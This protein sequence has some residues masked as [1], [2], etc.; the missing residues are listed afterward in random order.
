VVVRFQED[1]SVRLLPIPRDLWDPL[2]GRRVNEALMQGA[3][4]L[5]E[6]VRSA[7]GI[8]I[9]HYVEIDVPG[10]TRLVDELGGLPLRIDQEVRDPIAS[11]HLGRSACATL[12]GKTTL[13]L[14]RSR[15]LE[16]RDTAGPWQVDPSGDLGRAARGQVA[17]RVAIAELAKVRTNPVQI[18]RLTRLLADHATLD[19]GLTLQRLADLAGRLA[20]AGREGTST[21]GA[22]RG[23]QAERLPVGTAQIGDQA[24]LVPAAGADDVARSYGAASPPAPTADR[25]LPQPAG[26]P[27]RPC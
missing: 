5:V 25:T 23:V 27:I 21:G 19:E 18:D 11:L 22:Q 14:L 2:R 17:L 3:A 26:V 15:H 9:D 13:N 12:D 10:L 7:T 16:Y 20:A 8:P 24:V 4:A 6:S 1:G